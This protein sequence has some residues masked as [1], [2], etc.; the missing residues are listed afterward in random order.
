MGKVIST[1]EVVF[2]DTEELD[3]CEGEGPQV[4]INNER[5]MVIAFSTKPSA[6]ASSASGVIKYTVG[7]YKEDRKPTNWEL[8]SHCY[9]RRPPCA[10]VLKK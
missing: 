4:A 6:F 5:M 9:V 2:R 1:N 8:T 3:Q 10:C 7:K